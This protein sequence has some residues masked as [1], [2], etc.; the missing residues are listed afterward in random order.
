[1]KQEILR[2]ENLHKRFGTLDVLK[3]I[4]LTIQTGEV[5]AVIGPSGSGKSTL[6]RCLNFLETPTS[7]RILFQGELFGQYE[8]A[9]Q[10][11]PLAER[12]LN[13]QRQKMGMVF[14]RFN[15]FPHRTALGNII[16]APMHVKGVDR[17]AA[18]A[19]AEQ[20]LARVGLAD[21][22]DEYPVRLSGG[23]QQRVAIARALAMEP[24]LMLFDEATSA[25]DPELVGE[26]LQVMKDLAKDGMTMIV[27]THEMG[28]ARE[29]ANRVVSYL[30]LAQKFYFLIECD[31]GDFS[32]YNGI[33]IEEF[34][35]AFVGKSPMSLC[36]GSDFKQINLFRATGSSRLVIPSV[37]NPP[38]SSSTITESSWDYLSAELS[39]TD[40]ACLAKIV[41]ET[42][43]W[44]DCVQWDSESRNDGDKTVNVTK[45][46]KKNLITN[47]DPSTE[48]YGGGTIEFNFANWSGTVSYS[49]FDKPGTYSLTNGKER[50]TG[51]L[52]GRSNAGMNLSS[53]PA[54]APHPAPAGARRSG[55]WE[56]IYRLFS[57]H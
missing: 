43:V 13:R 26:V 15:L 16:E 9:G 17:R 48:W 21:K 14:Q 30:D 49:G 51:E 56:A 36:A 57:R 45:I 10:L 19:L 47:D 33:S 39:P 50:V 44:K 1:M 8:E 35:N 2:I 52:K 38:R 54:T 18:I 37:T 25:L 42:Y 7:G 22:R 20:L 55:Q 24:D 6:L 40:E 23:Q 34:S 4:D 53:S 29:V 3:G 28:F 12:E 32:K 46:Q 11:R 41:G 5:V 31:G 27:V